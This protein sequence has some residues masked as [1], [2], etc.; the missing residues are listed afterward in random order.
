MGHGLQMFDKSGFM[1]KGTKHEKTANIKRYKCIAA[2]GDEN[3]SE[4]KVTLTTTYVGNIVLRVSGG[5]H[6]HFFNDLFLLD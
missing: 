4:C 1:Y 3:N 6:N 5:F 2:D